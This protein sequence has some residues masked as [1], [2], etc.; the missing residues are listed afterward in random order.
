M[1]VCKVGGGKSQGST[2]FQTGRYPTLIEE[3]APQKGVGFM[4]LSILQELPDFTGRNCLLL[5]LH[6]R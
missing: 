2:D 1:D 5:A 4:N 3:R 6:S